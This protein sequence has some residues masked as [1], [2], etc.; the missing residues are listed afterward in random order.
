MTKAFESLLP[1]NS[2]HFERAL[3]QSIARATALDFEIDRLWNPEAV[4]K[5]FLPYLA[6]SLG[7][8]IWPDDATLSSDPKVAEQKKRQ[9]IREYLVIR[10]LR[11]TKESI[12]RAYKAINAKVEIIERP[13]GQAFRFKLKVS[14]D[15]LT[16]ELR[17]EVLRLTTLLKPVRTLFELEVE[18]IGEKRLGLYATARAT[19]IARFGVRL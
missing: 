6:W 13:G 2:T 18:F 19:P 7:V 10:K 8:E 14:G 9:L 17:S 1:K 12:E 16:P 5:K 3:E 11:G 15:P 4:S